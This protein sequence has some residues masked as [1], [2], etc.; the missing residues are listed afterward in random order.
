MHNIN[1]LKVFWN[2]ENQLLLS[3]PT[4]SQ[5]R[6]VFVQHLVLPSPSWVQVS[7]ELPG[8]KTSK[9]RIGMARIGMW[10]LICFLHSMCDMRVHAGCNLSWP[11]CR[12]CGVPQWRSL[13]LGSQGAAAGGGGIQKLAT[14]GRM[15]V[16][17]AK[18]SRFSYFWSRNGRINLVICE[19]FSTTCNFEGQEQEDNIDWPI[20]HTKCIIFLGLFYLEYTRLRTHTQ[21]H[22]SYFIA[23]ILIWTSTHFES[24]N[25][26]VKPQRLNVP[27]VE[28]SI[29]TMVLW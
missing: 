18:M 13:R 8:W 6:R 2:N 22:T 16:F 5:C 17:V 26:S 29:I 4:S 28:V 25:K 21:T 14:P 7:Y 23:Y 19:R 1:T 11:D 3:F 20:V 10:N 24:R 9:A 27:G 12:R 15:D